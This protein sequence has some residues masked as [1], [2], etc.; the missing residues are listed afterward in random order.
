MSK[1]EEKLLQAFVVLAKV[2]ESV[3]QIIELFQMGIW[4][5]QEQRKGEK[6]CV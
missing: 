2:S 4:T 5:K 6:V 3:S 1:Y